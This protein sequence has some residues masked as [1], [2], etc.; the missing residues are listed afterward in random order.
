MLVH[1]Y[2]IYLCAK[3]EHCSSISLG[4][5]EPKI[6]GLKPRLLSRYG[7]ENSTIDFPELG[8]LISIS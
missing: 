8:F 6:W 4:Q 5:G 3:F 1:I 2:L 7:V